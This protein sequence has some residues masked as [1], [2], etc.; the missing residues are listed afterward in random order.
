MRISLL[1]G[2]F[3]LA[4][5]AA[6]S[7]CSTPE[8]EECID[9]DE[10][11]CDAGL[12]DDFCN[13]KEEAV[14]DAEHCHLKVGTVQ[15]PAEPK[16]GVYISTLSDGGVDRDWYF[17]QLPEGLTAR[18]LLHVNGGYSA[19]QTAVNFSINVLKEG[20]DGTLTSIASDV[21][22]HGA[23]APKPVDLILPFAE[24]GARLFVLVGNEQTTNQ[25]KVDN[26]NPYSLMV[27]IQDDPDTNE[28]NDTTPTAIA[29]SA[30]G[31]EQR[32][33]QGGY[34]ATTDDVDLFSFGLQQAGRQIIYLHITEAG[35]HPTSPPPDYRLAY[36]LYDPDG[37]PISEGQMDN[38]FQTIDLAT[39]RLAPK[40]G[41]YR[42]AIF[43][44]KPPGD[45]TPV[46]GDLRVRYEVEV[47][48]LPDLD[49][50]EPNDTITMAKALTL[51]PN[52]SQT[53]TGK[54]S[55]VPDE[56]WFRVS[57]P[58]R[59]TPSVLRWRFSAA[60]SGGRFEPLAPTATRQVRWLRQVSG[61]GTS[62]DRQQACIS[63]GAVCPKGY[64]SPQSDNNS[65]LVEAL[66]RASDPPQ[67]LWA[68]RNEHPSFSNM[69]NMVGSLPVAANAAAEYFVMVRDEGK[70]RLKYADD[71][72]WTL[73]I[74]W[75]DDADEAGRG[76]GAQVVNLGGSTNEVSGV[77]SYGYGRQLLQ[78]VERGEGIRGPEDY[79]AFDT[80]KDLYQFNV[81][82]GVSEDGGVAEQAWQL[83][84][85][86]DHGTGSRPPGDI[87][88]EMTFC[89]T[90]GSGTGL[91]PGAQNRLFA[92]NPSKLSPW[93]QPTTLQ[94]ATTLV[95][96]QEVGN[97]TV[98]TVEP[99][100]CQC[101]SSPR[102][103]AGRFFINV[104]AV[105]RTRDEPITYRLRQSVTTYPTTYAADGGVASCPAGCGFAR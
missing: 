63:D 77:L 90:G 95:S 23:R 37:Q 58:S 9:G 18:S 94:Y 55:T 12:P 45:T 8:V 29:L 72:D 75:E 34:L 48:V 104:A 56:E 22:S 66:C 76:A 59:S 80:D 53:V 20:A 42:L 46:K 96:R 24:S 27:E 84:W 97:T 11:V 105:D 40:T 74:S 68:Q 64:D 83:Q 92:Y 41:E 98:F 28:P 81:T 16:G 7:G 51:S 86:I 73:T 100:S 47:R 93:Y 13:S 60:T 49:T 5:L 54:L 38:A 52:G 65:V 19:P 50:N 4:A 91:C 25:V 14:A 82:S 99:V 101:L 17:A 102:M 15:A 70:G 30:S 1:C 36:V 61:A 26:R 3:A 10:D 71:R 2:L 103:A 33:T 69:K 6:L 85:V 44:Y 88:L 31:A 39:A 89:G 32:G 62:E 67:C 57:L 78:Q 21:D 35:T 79:D 43:G 87:S